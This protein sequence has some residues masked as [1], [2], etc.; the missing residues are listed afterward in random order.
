MRQ[1]KQQPEGETMKKVRTLLATAAL[2]VLATLFGAGAMATSA[3]ADPGLQTGHQ[4]TGTWNVTVEGGA[5]AL[6]SVQ[7]FTSSGQMIEM[8]TEPQ[9]SRTAQFGVWERT[10]GGLYA[11]TG[12][13]YRF[14]PK[15]NFVGT[16]KI[17][18]TIEL[19][20]DGNTFQ[21]IAR[22][23]IYDPNDKLVQS[24]VA[25]GSGVRMPVERISDQP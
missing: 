14:D 13:F 20:P 8:A 22:V 18:R 12:V 2:V 15:G 7:V 9:S 21:H 1:R 19:G 16:T 10:E 5:R 11:A 4:L 23:G 25:R 17:N 24:V 6:K 3:S